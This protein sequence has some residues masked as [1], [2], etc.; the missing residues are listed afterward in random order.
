MSRPLLFG[1]G[2]RGTRSRH[3]Q[4][5][6]FCKSSMRGPISFL[7]WLESATRAKEKTPVFAIWL[8][9]VGNDNGWQGTTS[10]SGGVAS[11][12]RD[13]SFIP[14]AAIHRATWTSSSEQSPSHRTGANRPSADAN[15]PAAPP[16]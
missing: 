7:N 5:C 9:Q 12:E 16:A 10:R 14:T 15:V 8:R 11:F 4:H 1:V 6:G 2:K 13:E 3:R